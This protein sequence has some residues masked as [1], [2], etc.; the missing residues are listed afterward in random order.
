MRKFPEENAEEWVSQEQSRNKAV[1]KSQIQNARQHLAMLQ[2]QKND[3]LATLASLQSQ[4]EEPDFDENAR[5]ITYQ[6]DKSSYF[7]ALKQHEDRSEELDQEI[8]AERAVFRNLT[9]ERQKMASKLKRLTQEL[10]NCER[11]YKR[12]DEAWRVTQAAARDLE[13]KL[14]TKE[15]KRNELAQMCEDIKQEL[16]AVTAQVMDETRQHYNEL[17]SQ[18]SELEGILEEEKERNQQL[19]ERMKEI[20]FEK[21]REL[22]NK[23]DTLKKARGV[24]ENQK[25]RKRLDKELRRVNQ[26]LEIETKDL[27]T[28]LERKQRLM[29]KM[30]D[31]LGDD[32]PGDG[33]GEMAK[34]ILLSKIES[35]EQ[36][37]MNDK[38]DELSME[39]EYQKELEEQM[40]LVENTW[41]V[42]EE[43]RRAVLEDF[44]EELKQCKRNGYIELLTSEKQELEKRLARRWC[45]CSQ[46]LSFKLSRQNKYRLCVLHSKQACFTLNMSARR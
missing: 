17:S 12:E 18:I 19:Q 13:D 11:Q 37:D 6:D 15:T 23:R 26:L 35:V 34:I 21:K 43:E 5:I 10:K 3:L 14:F 40:K 4:K 46:C 29:M 38:L 22:E 2:S 20:E 44:Q 1:V 33:T 16:G 24:I 9:H 7:T 31:L 32:D 41:R 42:F 36:R 30:Q 8:E 25:E 28:A 27:Q 45:F 39:T